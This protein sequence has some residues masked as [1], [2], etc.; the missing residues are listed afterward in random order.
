MYRFDTLAVTATYFFSATPQSLRFDSSVVKYGA[1]G[2][3]KTLF[4]PCASCNTARSWSA[5]PVSDT[6]FA[7]KLRLI[8]K[9]E[10]FSKSFSSAM[11]ARNREGGLRIAFSFGLAGT[12]F[13]LDERTG[14]S[15]LALPVNVHG[16]DTGCAAYKL[17]S[18]F[19]P[20]RI[21]S[22]QKPG[23]GPSIR[24]VSISYTET[25][26]VTVSFTATSDVGL[27]EADFGDASYRESIYFKG[28]KR[29]GI[30][31]T[32]LIDSSN[33]RM[34]ITVYDLHGNAST[35]SYPIFEDKREA[36]RV[37]QARRKRVEQERVWAEKNSVN[38]ALYTVG[39]FD[40]NIG[41]WFKAISDA[42]VDQDVHQDSL[43]DAA[44]REAVRNKT[45][46]PDSAFLPKTRPD[47]QPPGIEIIGE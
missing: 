46:R 23:E 4:F 35:V 27:R 8:D 44:M 24:N 39:Q 17:A 31:K 5:S 10:E 41:M 29:E 15:T 43:R 42:L 12:S 37:A 20:T 11:L 26:Q 30:T 40:G 13:V 45:V 22:E 38:Q 19:N 9:A 18:F 28:T 25:Q 14:V 2:S 3:Y 32:L 21:A 47:S 33:Y 7:A 16:I 34:S 6:S 36:G 1:A